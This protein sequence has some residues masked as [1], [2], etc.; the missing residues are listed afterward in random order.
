MAKVLGTPVYIRHPVNGDVAEAVAF[1]RRGRILLVLRPE[2]RSQLS[3]WSSAGGAFFASRRTDI[4]EQPD[5]KPVRMSEKR[6]QEVEAF[7]RARSTFE[8]RRWQIF[9]KVHR[10]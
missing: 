4:H 7:M 8:L 10:A 5:A 1:V 9:S 3:S 6:L 2:S